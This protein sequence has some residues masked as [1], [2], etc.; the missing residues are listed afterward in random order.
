MNNQV[1]SVVTAGTTV[2]VSMPV[3]WAIVGLAA[4]AIVVGLVVEKILD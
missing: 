1:I 4:T 3:G 2:A